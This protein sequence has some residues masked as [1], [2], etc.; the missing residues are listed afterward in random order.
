[1]LRKVFVVTIVFFLFTNNLFAKEQNSFEKGEV[2]YFQ[3][4]FSDKSD[5][6]LWPTSIM[7]GGSSFNGRISRKTVIRIANKK[8]NVNLDNLELLNGK[9]VFVY[10]RFRQVGEGEGS[11][12]KTESLTIY[13]LSNGE[14]RGR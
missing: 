8:F 7:T 10:G 1:M 9:R 3:F 14:S 4:P 13:I 11:F 12:Y 6:V 2:G 5:F